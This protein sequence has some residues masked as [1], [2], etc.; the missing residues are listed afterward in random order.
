MNAATQATNTERP[1]PTPQVEDMIQELNTAKAQY[2]DARDDL[3]SVVDQMERNQRS[4][5]AAQAEATQLNQE[6]R[7]ATHRSGMKASGEVR[8]LIDASMAARDN[9]ER[10]AMLVEE[11]PNLRKEKQEQTATLRKSYLQKTD[12]LQGPILA[13]KAEAATRALKEAGDFSAAFS[14]INEHLANLYEGFLRSRAIYFNM[15]TDM[16]ARESEIAL[17]H[18]ARNLTLTQGLVPLLETLGL[19]LE[20][21]IPE[22]LRKTRLLSVEKSTTW[23]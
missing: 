2:L 4:L 9:A 13:S 8:K 18:E 15:N 14:D 22:G 20:A 10:M 16:S 5:I 1:E 19:D 11:G 21:D 17:K 3:K 6:W 23:D 7:D 12:K